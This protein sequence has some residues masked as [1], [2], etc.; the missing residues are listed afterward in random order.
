MMPLLVKQR[1][2]TDCRT[3][4]GTFH[5]GQLAIVAPD[6]KYYH[7]SCYAKET[8]EGIDLDERQIPDGGAIR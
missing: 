1:F 6:G 4:G 2:R 3:C 5:V 8:K 7:L